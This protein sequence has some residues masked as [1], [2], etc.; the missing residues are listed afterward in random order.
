MKIRRQRRPSEQLYWLR[1]QRPD[2]TLR[3]RVAAMTV[4]LPTFQKEG[5]RLIQVP[6]AQSAN[7]AASLLEKHKPT[8]TQLKEKLG[9]QKD[10]T[11]IAWMLEQ[12]EQSDDLD[13]ILQSLLDG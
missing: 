4:S 1:E 7:R 10:E 5:N 11:V 3:D 2:A 6:D 9:F 13:K 8:I 12:I